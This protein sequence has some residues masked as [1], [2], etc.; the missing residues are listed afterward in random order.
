M[1]TLRAYM[2]AIGC[3]GLSANVPT[4]DYVQMYAA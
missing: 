4:G 2:G 3:I 1:S